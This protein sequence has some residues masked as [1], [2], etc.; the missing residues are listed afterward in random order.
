MFRDTEPNYIFEKDKQTT[1]AYVKRAVVQQGKRT[2]VPTETEIAVEQG[3]V[4]YSDGSSEL[5]HWEEVV[6]LKLQS[7]PNID[8]LVFVHPNGCFMISHCNQPWFFGMRDKDSSNVEYGDNVIV[9]DRNKDD[10]STFTQSFERNGLRI[11]FT[12]SFGRD[13]E[14]MWRSLADFQ[15]LKLQ[16]LAQNN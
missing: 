14:E 16:R 5:L 15:S 4:F 7:T 8:F 9:F 2:T 3:A 11:E 13:Q 1:V 12:F 6:D 10:I